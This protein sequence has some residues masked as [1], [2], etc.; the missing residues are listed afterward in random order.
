M[1]SS[2]SCGRD[3]GQQHDR[4]WET[5]VTYEKWQLDAL[6]NAEQV[7]EDPICFSWVEQKHACLSGIATW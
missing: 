1:T 4:C 7:A 5:A 3:A 2:Q 6:G